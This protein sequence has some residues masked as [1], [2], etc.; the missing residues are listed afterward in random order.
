VTA[1][2]CES[3]V[4]E[5]DAF[6]PFYD[7][8]TAASDYDRWTGFV[9]ELAQRLGLRG[10]SLLDLACGT[11]KSFLPFLERG[12]EVTGCDASGA[13][14]GEAARK[15]P[16]VPLVRADLREVGS[17][18]RFDLVTCFDDSL[19]YLLDERDL[20]RSFLSIAANLHPAGLALFD[21]NTLLAYRTIFAS[22]SVT[23]G[24]KAVFAWHGEAASDSPPGCLAAA[25]L[26]IFAACAGGLY[27]RV[28]SRH[29]Q[30]HFPTDRVTTLLAQAGLDCLAVR[31]VCDDGALDLELDEA[32]HLKVLY[33]ARLTKGGDTQ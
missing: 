22:D 29:A 5:Y 19:N 20:G 26:E 24:D 23:V 30:R 16:G 28:R 14:L 17:L 9:L 18:G 25:Q 15:A 2:A 33:A 11:G 8:F 27:E 31:G 12:F 1:T 13:M 4:T 6:A 7:A 10:K 3:T 21:L 32:R